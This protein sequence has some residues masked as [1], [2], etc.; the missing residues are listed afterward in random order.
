MKKKIPSYEE[1]DSFYGGDYKLDYVAQET[2]SNFE[3][4]GKWLYLGA[5]I[6]DGGFAKV[7][8][9]MGDLASRSYSSTRPSYYLFCAFKFK[10]NISMQD[11]KRVEND[12]LLR[13]DRLHCN[14][15]GSS[16]RMIHYESGK[17]SECFYPVDFFSFYKDLHWEIYDGHR[18]SFVI[19]GYKNKY[20]MDDGEFVDCI[21]ND[22]QEGRHDEYRKMILQHD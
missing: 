19:C 2:I 7:G 3:S 4:I 20:G 12:V 16:K 11:V 6:L 18:N 21:F 10:H 8:M 17:P 22:Q 9:T 15:D 1:F 5:D 14:D 13:L